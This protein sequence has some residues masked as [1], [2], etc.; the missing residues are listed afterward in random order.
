MVRLYEEGQRVEA[1]RHYARV[2]GEELVTAKAVVELLAGE[3]R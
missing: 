3:P 2:S 1:F